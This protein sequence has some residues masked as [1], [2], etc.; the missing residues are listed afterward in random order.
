MYPQLA[1][2]SPE[3]CCTGGLASHVGPG[4]PRGCMSAEWV[5]WF[6]AVTQVLSLHSL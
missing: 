1:S 2:L 4:L 5:P 6:A 3:E